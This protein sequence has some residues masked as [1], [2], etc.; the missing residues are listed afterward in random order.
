MRQS[1]LL[2]ETSWAGGQWDL[3]YFSF[4]SLHAFPGISQVLGG[5]EILSNAWPGMEIA[6]LKFNSSVKQ[7]TGV[8]LSYQ[9]HLVRTFK[10]K[11]KNC[12]LNKLCFVC[13]LVS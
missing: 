10:G 9:E 1:P 8:C 12:A 11:F 4:I 5:N 7:W 3:L 13:L 2:W 6:E